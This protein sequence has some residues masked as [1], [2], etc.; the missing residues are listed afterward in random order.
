MPPSTALRWIDRLAGLGLVDR[1]QDTLD[2][3]KTFVTL[4]GKAVRSME[5]ALDSAAESDR[6][7]GLAR[8]ES[9]Q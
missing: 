4:T 1:I 9:I 6:K 7:L 5:N 3:R 2:G 8:L